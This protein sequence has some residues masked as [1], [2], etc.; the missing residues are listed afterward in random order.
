MKQ[1][2]IY[3]SSKTKTNHQTTGNGSKDGPFF[4]FVLELR[5]RKLIIGLFV[6]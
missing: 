6:D 5:V 2:F 1:D 3:R 4:L